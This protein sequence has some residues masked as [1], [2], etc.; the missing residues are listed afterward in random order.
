MFLLS[1]I[2][3]HPTPIPSAHIQTPRYIGPRTQQG[4]G[5]GPQE[6]QGLPPPPP[7]PPKP[8]P[9][10]PK[11]GL[12]TVSKGTP[13]L[14]LLL[15]QDVLLLQLW[16]KKEWSLFGFPLGLCLG[17]EMLGKKGPIECV[18]EEKGDT[19]TQ[20]DTNR[21]THRGDTGCCL[22]VS[23][24]LCLSLSVG[25]LFLLSPRASPPPLLPLDTRLSVAL[26][27]RDTKRQ[28]EA[29]RDGDS[30]RQRQRLE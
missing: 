7:P 15:L 6:S 21:G 25:L 1:A 23:L 28:T 16:G 11:K 13:L 4:G 20:S 2:S 10:S 12:S 9:L 22:P 14:L 29:P 24:S 26:S 17:S 3:R 5:R 18:R 30:E 8:R 27:P 19:K